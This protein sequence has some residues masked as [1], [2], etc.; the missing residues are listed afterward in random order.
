MVVLRAVVLF[1]E[2]KSKIIMLMLA[3]DLKGSSV[4]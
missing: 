1:S 4:V 2:R 3:T